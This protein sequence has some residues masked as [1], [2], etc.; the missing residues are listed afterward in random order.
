MWFC[1][2]VKYDQSFVWLAGYRSCL[3][4][5]GYLYELVTK[6][7]KKF[8]KFLLLQVH[9]ILVSKEEKEGLDEKWEK[10]RKKE[11]KKHIYRL[12]YL[13]VRNI[14]LAMVCYF[15]CINNFFF[16]SELFI[17]SNFAC[18]CIIS[19]YLFDWYVKEEKKKFVYF[20][21][22]IFFF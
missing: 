18:L 19:N 3:V 14:S 13:P 10:E 16:S 22:F 9:W 5:N 17:Y 4:P 20:L 8:F 1:K 11:K 7:E 21:W 12:Y 2:V 15:S 6:K